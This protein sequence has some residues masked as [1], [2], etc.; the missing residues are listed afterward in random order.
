MV[1]RPK[2]TL[3]VLGRLLAALVRI[4]V[5]SV[6]ALLV[7]IGVMSLG[8]PLIPKVILLLILLAAYLYFLLVI[9]RQ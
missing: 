3:K 6:L 7:A 5:C 8:M 9:I 2:E 4:D 1:N